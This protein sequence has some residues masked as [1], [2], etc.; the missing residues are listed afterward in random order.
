MAHIY[1]V[2]LPIKDGWIFH[3]YV[4]LPEGMLLAVKSRST[5]ATD[6]L[7]AA[8]LP[9]P[10]GCLG[11]PENSPVLTRLCWEFPVEKWGFPP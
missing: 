1:I 8:H 6:H 3:S 2:D 11:N 9:L 5:L 10:E 7:S 4:K